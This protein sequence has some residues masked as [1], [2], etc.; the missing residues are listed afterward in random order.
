VQAKDKSGL[1]DAKIFSL[2]TFVN[3]RLDGTL[4]CGG[5]MGTYKLF[6]NQ[7]TLDGSW[8]LAGLCD[9]ESSNQNGSIEKYFHEQ[10][11]IEETNGHMVLLNAKGEIRI[12]LDPL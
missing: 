8:V 10:M 2:V 3:G 12:V 4:G 6:G 11:R 1:I 5:L 9:M 7:V